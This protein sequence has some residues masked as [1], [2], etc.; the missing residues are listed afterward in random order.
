MKTLDALSVLEDADPPARPVMSRHYR[1]KHLDPTR[2]AESI[3]GDEFMRRAVLAMDN[4][5]YPGPSS[6]LTVISGYPDSL[7][8]KMLFH[9]DGSK[10]GVLLTRAFVR[11]TRT[12]VELSL[13]EGFA[14]AV[15]RETQERVYGLYMNVCLKRKNAEKS[16]WVRTIEAESVLAG[17]LKA[18]ASYVTSDESLAPP[19]LPGL[20]VDENDLLIA[21]MEHPEKIA[22]IIATVAERG[23]FSSDVIAQTLATEIPE[24]SKGL[25]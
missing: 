14:E 2:E 6:L 11:F 24:L 12:N 5:T 13:L 7:L 23:I 17:A 15:T 9:L 20:N 1:Y 21:M 25:L 18:F 19:P 16:T 8:D 4:L 3:K 22:L 10:L